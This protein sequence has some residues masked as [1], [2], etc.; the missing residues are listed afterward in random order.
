MQ[1]LGKGTVGRRKLAARMRS[2]TPHTQVVGAETGRFKL[3]SAF[4]KKVE[5]T[6]RNGQWPGGTSRQQTV[7][8]GVAIRKTNEETATANW[9]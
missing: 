4:P 6:G 1:E 7:E 9:L 5:R 8:P 2:Q 3:L